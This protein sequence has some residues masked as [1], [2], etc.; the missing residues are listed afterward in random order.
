M[1]K[2]IQK[3]LVKFKNKRASEWFQ[4]GTP[5]L[6]GLLTVLLI[7]H[8]L[9]FG[10]PRESLAA[11]AESE[12][13]RFSLA[14]TATPV[15]RESHQ[16]IS[17]SVSD[18]DLMT[19]SR[20]P[21]S[22]VSD[23]HITEYANVLAYVSRFK[24]RWVV[25]GWL[26]HA[27]PLTP[28]YLSP[29]TS[30][31]DRLELRDRVTIA[32]NFFASGNIDAN[33]AKRY[34]IVEARDC[35][36]DINLHCTYSKEWTW[37]PQQIF[38]RFLTEPEKSISTNLPHHL[39]NIVL[40]L[41]TIKS[42]SNF[43]FMDAREPVAGAI[44]TDAIIFIGNQATQ[45]V[46]FRDNKE[47][48][49]RS[50]IAQSNP[51]R[52]L[53]QEGTPWHIFWAALT[54]MFIESRALHV[55][56]GI[57]I[58]GLAVLCGLIIF[59]LAFR[60]IDHLTLIIPVCIISAL[61]LMNLL[62]ISTIRYY[63]P[64]TPIL[65]TCITAVPSAIFLMG[66]LNNYKKWK[67]LAIARRADESG[68]LKQN[69]LQLISHNLNTPIAQLKGLLEILSAESPDSLALGRA[70]VLTDYIRITA[71]A[72]LATSAAPTRSLSIQRRTLR[73]VLE[74]FLDDEAGFLKRMKLEVH[75]RELN[76]EIENNV[77]S[78]TLGLDFDLI[79]NCLVSALILQA[80]SNRYSQ[81]MIN[82]IVTPGAEED[83]DV[84][85]IS[86]QTSGNRPQDSHLDPPPFM[87]ETIER[88]LDAV[89]AA[90]LISFRSTESEATISFK[91]RSDEHP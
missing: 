6:I 50:F 70:L 31:I 55:A 79:S 54:A 37:M 19:I 83:E 44:P 59:S 88:Y 49:Q 41:P 1:I 34:N 45:D 78:K 61:L 33:L 52:T 38:S 43:K 35:Y 57:V 87:R 39:P 29:L 90:N 51:R 9:H 65:I 4:F 15:H 67:L 26:T 32:I 58:Y 10:G 17:F 36:H 13:M 77:W 22:A 7:I 71:K 60:K 84:L 82:A 46:M 62:T 40:N 24:P 47:V 80:M 72:A 64:I 74:G 85:H 12:I 14:N 53:Q 21:N 2:T 76:D 25:L 5:I 89:I 63:L 66:A 11:R 91:P 81:V 30:L 48:L 28:E 27:H 73:S 3:D 68:D 8:I 56:P 75:V 42:L 86:L 23:A 20:A 16:V 18:S 69:F